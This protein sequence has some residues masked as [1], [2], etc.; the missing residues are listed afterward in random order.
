M[1]RPQFEDHL[2]FR[3]EVERLKVLA[4]LQIPDMDLVPILGSK[5]YVSQILSDHRLISKDAAS[6]LA[7]FFRV[8]PHSFL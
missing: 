7:Q 1:R 4:A 5:S 8:S 3:S 6:K 2:V